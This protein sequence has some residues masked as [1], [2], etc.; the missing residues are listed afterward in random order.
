MTMHKALHSKDD[1]ESLKV[2]RK[3]VRGLSSIE[4]F[5]EAPIQGF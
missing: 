5:V 1:Q 3:G 2:S 4:D